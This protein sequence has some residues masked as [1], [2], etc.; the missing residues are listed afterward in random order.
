MLNN[1]VSSK[2]I[3]RLLFKQMKSLLEFNIR[4]ARQIDRERFTVCEFDIVQINVRMRSLVA[5]GL[6]Y[7]LIKIN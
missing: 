1:F 7:N 6:E 2:Q 4:F 5:L 3:T